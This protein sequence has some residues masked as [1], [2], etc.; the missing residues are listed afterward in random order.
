MISKFYGE[1]ICLELSSNVSYKE[2]KAL[3]DAI[4]SLGARV[5]FI[6]N[7]KVSFLVKDNPL[8]LDTYKCRTAFKLGIPVVHSNFV[9]ESIQNKSAKIEGFIIKNKAIEEN[10]KK[11][12]IASNLRGNL[13]IKFFWPYFYKVKFF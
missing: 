1:I 2:K 7:S 4:I 11:G 5:S 3:I 8:N 6:L 13:Y 9:A 10:L 12:V